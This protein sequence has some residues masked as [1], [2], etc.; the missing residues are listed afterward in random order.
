MPSPQWQRDLDALLAR[1]PYVGRGGLR[2]LAEDLGVSYGTVRKW[3]C[4][5]AQPNAENRALLESKRQ[6]R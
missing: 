1:S 4:G 6:G 2:K 3:S 5:M